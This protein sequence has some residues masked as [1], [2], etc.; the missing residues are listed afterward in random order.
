MKLARLFVVCGAFAAVLAS[1]RAQVFEAEPNDTT[2]QASPMSSGVTI[3][4]QLLSA[5]DVDIFSILIPA[6]GGLKIGFTGDNT[7]VTGPFG[8]FKIDVLNAGGATLSSFSRVN[9][10]SGTSPLSFTTNVGL[11]AGDRYFVRIEPSAFSWTSSAYYLTA[12]FQPLIPLIATQPSSQTVLAG[13]SAT[14]SVTADGVAPLTYQ[15]FKNGT[16]IA[17]ATSASLQFANMRMASEN[18]GKR[19]FSD[20]G[21]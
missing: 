3:R 15:W 1:G 7:S 21:K 16:A 11:P 8:T 12:T 19:G 17:S 9:L 14:M 2:A 10:S 20:H 5:S 4:G 18:D 13:R 6:A